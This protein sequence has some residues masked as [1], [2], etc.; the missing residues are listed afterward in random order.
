MANYETLAAQVAA[1]VKTNGAQAITGANLQTQ[2]LAMIASI[3]ANYQYAGVAIPSTVPGTPDQ[4][5]FYIAATAGTYTNFGGIVL[6][7]GEVAVIKGSGSSWTKE[8]TGVATAAEVSQLGQYVDNPE[9]V[10]V[11]TDS[12]DKILYGVKTDGKFY[13]GNGC[14]PQ[15]VEYVTAKLEE[16]EGDFTTLLNAKV[17]KVA[18]KSL[19]DAE[20]ASSQSAVENPEWIDVKTDSEDKV[21][22]GTKPD[23]TKVIECDL[24]VKGKIKNGDSTEEQGLE[25]QKISI[26]GA[27]IENTQDPE[28]RIEIKTDA[29]G[30]IIS[31][32]DSD[33]V[34]HEKV[35]VE[36]NH[37][38]LSDEG[39]TE[40][41]QALKDSGFNP[42]GEGDWSDAKELHIQEPYYAIVNFSGINNI[43]QE[44]FVDMKGYMEFFDMNGNYFKKE[45][46]LN[47]QGR[48]SLNLAKKNIA[49][50]ICNNNG[51]DDDDTFKLRIG[52]WV[53]QDSF[54][55]K[56]YMNDY[57]KCFCP[58]AYKLYDEIVKTRG[59]KEDYVWKRALID[60]DSVTETSIG[61]TDA[62]V[63]FNTGAR[64]F[65][66]GFPCI[67]CLN[68]DFYGIYAWQI[69]KHRD[70]YHMDK[71]EAKQIHLDGVINGSSI[72]N[73]NGD[74]SEIVWDNNPYT[75]FE[76]RNPKN[77]YL[78]DGTK[79]DADF[80]TGELMDSTSQY[81][82]STNRDHVRTNEVKGYIVELS[83]VM[84][85]IAAA[86]AV[87][88][89]SEKTAS[90]VQTFKTVF[91]TYFDID[92]LVD[93]LIS[94]DI[95]FNY[96]GF[97]SNW[98][99]I[100][101]DGVKWYIGLYDADLVL[102]NRALMNEP[103]FLEPSTV[104]VISHPY[105]TTGYQ[106][107]YLVE[108]YTEELEERY[109]QLRK[110]ETISA[111]HIV[112]LISNWISRLGN[113]EYYSK[114]QEKWTEVREPDSIFRIQKWLT[115]SIENMD[116]IYN[117]T[118][119]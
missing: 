62:E 106:F 65:P 80:N 79:Y 98:Q 90:D 57:F 93:Y 36:T 23:G 9:W 94:C 28:G 111:N 59:D 71:K 15:V 104:H 96:D 48:S 119:Q 114:E 109:A 108:F 38:G 118:N 103:G 55:L 31:Y 7:D 75:G 61:N 56:G 67:V 102:G 74:S 112:S 13:F 41:Q 19:I 29:E 105:V 91:E 40:F 100:T 39:M 51:W 20:F 73:A 17:D 43:P 14:P 25:T 46:I 11:V 24:E 1:V 89:A 32:R 33:G 60:L 115:T 26:N 12:Q 86:K 21:L 42:G 44:K 35:G 72:L 81:Y 52:D 110:L 78:M 83:R 64:C 66:Q 84:S 22:E 68:G 3:G 50:D 107:N 4:K 34:K 54:H 27:T 58:I 45:V 116:N 88:D 85:I 63:Q 99:W 30:R 82:D 92:N 18:G 49:L 113:N 5:V 95:L 2:L 8:V 76:I 87:Y 47:A 10:Q 69:K 16:L 70:N 6:A 117:Y 53:A 97:S 37:L 101:Y 77:L